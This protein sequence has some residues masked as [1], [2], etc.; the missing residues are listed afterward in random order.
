MR[1]TADTV[2]TVPH[3]TPWTAARHSRLRIVEEELHCK[4]TL[5]VVRSEAA[6]VGVFQGHHWQAE[7]ISPYLR[8]TIQPKLALLATFRSLHRTTSPVGWRRSRFQHLLQRHLSSY[9]EHAYHCRHT[10]AGRS[11]GM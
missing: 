11:H 8:A 10:D 7:V 5:G 3:R 4:T 6:D 9:G 2:S 1:P